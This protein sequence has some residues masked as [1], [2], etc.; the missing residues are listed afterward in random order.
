VAVFAGGQIGARRSVQL[1]RSKV[2]TAFG[3][4]LVVIALLMG[5]K[6]LL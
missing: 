4:F 1:D 6:A 2:K 3:W 5:T